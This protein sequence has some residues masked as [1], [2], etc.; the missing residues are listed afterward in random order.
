VR[1][2]QEIVTR[3]TKLFGDLAYTRQPAAFDELTRY[4]G[5]EERLPQLKDTVPGTPEALHAAREIAAHVAGAPIEPDDVG[6]NE[7]DAMRRWAEAQSSWT[8]R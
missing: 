6:E 1:G 3:A 2:E 4:L 8:F 5:S 7:I